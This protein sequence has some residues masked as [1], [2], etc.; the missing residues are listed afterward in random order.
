[1]GLAFTASRLLEESGGRQEA[2]MRRSLILVLAISVLLVAQAGAQIGKRVIIQAGT[3]EDKAISE[4]NAATD[5]AQKLALIEKFLAE[6]GQGDM[7][8]VAY[9]LYVSHYLAEKNFDKV[10]G[11][12]E[13]ILSIDPDNFP[14]GVNLVRAAQE[15]GDQAKLFAAGERVGA[16]LARHK[17]KPAPNGV[18]AAAWEQQKANALAEARDNITYV[19]YVLFSS[20]YQ[21][22]DPAAKAALFERFLAA[23]PDS[24][25]GANAQTMVV[26]AYQQ[27]Q[28][29]P[30]MLEFGRGVLARD[31]N[32][33]GMLLLLADYF[34]ERGEQLDKAEEYSKKA[35]EL[36]ASAQKPAEVTDEQWQKQLSLQRG[37]AWTAL[38]QVYIARKRVAQALE[39]LRTAAPLLKSDPVTYAR[40]QY[41]MGFALLNLNRISEARAALA[42]AAAINSPYRNLAQEK[43]SSLP[44]GAPAKKRP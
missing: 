22:R 4:I 15:K 11:Y 34:S 20:A 24:P 36:L 28:N 39:A 43:L 32:N 18:D 26:A 38:G 27:A 5:P 12:C 42:E 40:N 14:A 44:G 3:P 1:V 13:K 35:L 7:A 10:S 21:T 23:F 41:R 2:T 16:I 25:Y 17:A 9:E 33:I 31:A 8:I 37:L 19:Q 29:Y 6:H 30:K